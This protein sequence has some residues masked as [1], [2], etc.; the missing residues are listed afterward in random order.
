MFPLKLGSDDRFRR[1]HAGLT[2]C[3]FSEQ[4]ICGR[5]QI[6]AIFR[7]TTLREGRP[8]GEAVHDRLDAL[9]RLLM[10]GHALPAGQLRA[11]L[12]ETLLDDLL[13]LD[14]VRPT[15]ADPSLLGATVHLYCVGRL[16]IA[17]DRTFPLDRD[18]TRT[19][20]D[21]VYPAITANTGRFLSFLPSD[22]CQ[23]LLDLCAGTGV[24]ALAAASSYARHAWAAD[25][26]ARSTHFAEFNRRMNLLPNVSAVQ[27]DLFSAVSGLQFDRIVAHPPYVPAA[28][29][30]ILFRD[31]GEDGELVFR[32]IVE[33]LPDFL[34]PGGRAYVLTRATDREG[35]P[36]QDRVRQWLGPRQADFDVFI[37][38]H[39]EQ[40]GPEE[41]RK[42]AAKYQGDLLD[43]GAAVPIPPSLKVTAI[44]YAVIIVQRHD[45][46]RP[47][48]TNRCRKAID[49]AAGAIEWFRLWHARAADPA[50]PPIL[51]SSRPRPN[52]TF[53]LEVTHAFR[54]GALTPIDFQLKT[55]YPYL[56]N[57]RIQPWLTFLLGL[58]DGSRT[59]R[60]IIRELRSQEVVDDQ[61]TGDELLSI[62]VQLL[63]SGF[64]EIDE[65][66]LPGRRD[67]PAP[68]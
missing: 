32:R 51:L 25:L 39:S 9:I 13:A 27:G 33:G 49:L 57:A 24:A 30:K 35:A 29:Q 11:L 60:E 28:E 8:T 16:F 43:A 59:I 19:R 62:F 47:P 17:S 40:P 42:L 15:A 66:P 36:L 41:I 55:D 53:R 12:P 68:V 48:L 56:S 52:P 3:G 2:E 44:L 58:C 7:F 4:A 54:N 26:G 67:A 21:V 31:G 10:D 50:F 34:S 5:C 38:T 65:Y 64:L 22:P 1:L 61:T 18:D 20:E 23:R 37:V 46:S 6:P 45:S 63:G 14:V